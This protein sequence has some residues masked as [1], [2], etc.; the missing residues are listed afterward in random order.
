MRP[1]TIGDCTLPVSTCVPGRDASQSHFNY[2]DISAVDRNLKAITN[3]RCLASA[4]APSRVRLAL[5][6]GDILVSTVRPN[7]NTVAVVPPRYDGSVG[8]TG[9]CVLRCDER[10]LHNRYLFHWTQT[11]KFFA[12]LTRQATGAGYP[13]VSDATIKAEQ[14]PP[15]PISEQRRIA[16]IL[17]DADAPIELSESYRESGNPGPEY[18]QRELRR[19]V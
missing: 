7:L 12:N 14:V 13:A 17:D 16:E 9:F 19:P 18:L 4:D 11:P 1:V 5:A 2:I 15:P 6:S 10:K 8:S 3:A